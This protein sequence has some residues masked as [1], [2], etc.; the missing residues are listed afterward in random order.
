MRLRTA[1]ERGGTTTTA[2]GAARRPHPASAT[3]SGRNQPARRYPRHS[4]SGWRRRSAGCRRPHRRATCSTAAVPCSCASRSATPRPG[5]IT[6]APC[7]PRAGARDAC[8]GKPAAPSASPLGGWSGTP[9]V[10]A[11]AAQL[12]RHLMP[13]NARPQDEQDTSQRRPVGRAADHLSASADPAATALPP[14][15]RG[16]Q[17]REEPPL[18]NDSAQ[19]FPKLCDSTGQV[20]PGPPPESHVGKGIGQGGRRIPA[21]ASEPCIGIAMAGATTTLPVLLKIA[22]EGV[23]PLRRPYWLPASSVRRRVAGSAARRRR[24][25]EVNRPAGCRLTLTESG[26]PDGSR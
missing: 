12:G 11:A 15:A 22:S 5:R 16:H 19:V 18:L 10:V 4:S 21:S 25:T 23:H 14:P 9:R 8:Q 2:S 13:L 17:E 1:L 26:R 24:L 6:A 7:C 20:A 3:W